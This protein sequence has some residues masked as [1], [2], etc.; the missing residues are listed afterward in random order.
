MIYFAI[1]IDEAIKALHAMKA[2]GATNVG[3]HYRFGGKQYVDMTQIELAY[4]NSKNELV[5]DEDDD[6]SPQPGDITI[7]MIK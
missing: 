6:Y 2:A 1:T 5:G 3:T 4:C 7:A